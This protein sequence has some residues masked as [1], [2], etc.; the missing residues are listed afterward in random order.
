MRNNTEYVN[1]LSTCH[2]TWDG[3]NWNVY[4]YDVT[5]SQLTQGW[6][7]KIFANFTSASLAYT[8]YV[9]A[10]NNDVVEYQNSYSISLSGYD[11]TRSIPAKLSWLDNRYVIFFHELQYRYIEA[12]AGQKTP[13]LRFRF[14]AIISSH[15]GTY[16]RLRIYLPDDLAQQPFT[17]VNSHSNMVAQFLPALSGGDRDFSVGWASE[18]YVLTASSR[19]YIEVDI[20]YGGLYSGRD[21]LLQLSEVNTATSSFYMPTT[22][23]RTKI[24]W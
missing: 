10:E 16:D 4:L 22:P 13:Y 14:R 15:T 19:Y 24:D 6:W 17:P 12:V 2:P 23:S 8:S 5:Q 20:R 9:R 3:S 21:Y 18:A 7:I 1:T 11:S